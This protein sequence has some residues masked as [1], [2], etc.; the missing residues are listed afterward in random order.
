MGII[1]F[2]FSFHHLSFLSYFCSSYFCPSFRALIGVRGRSRP[3]FTNFAPE[4]AACAPFF[5]NSKFYKVLRANGLRTNREFCGG[6]F[7]PSD[8]HN[9][10]IW[11]DMSFFD[12]L[13]CFLCDRGGKRQAAPV[14]RRRS[15]H[16][17]DCLKTGRIRRSILRPWCRSPAARARYPRL[18]RFARQGPFPV[19]SGPQGAVS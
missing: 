5:L 12:N 17:A 7:F 2:H 3:H 4:R 9:P 11:I 10:Y 18:T 14:C 8:A 13:L 19:E 15:G 16:R 6:M 1:E